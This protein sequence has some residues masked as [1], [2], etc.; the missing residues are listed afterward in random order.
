VC[1]EFAARVVSR[2]GDVAELDYEGERRS[3]SALLVPDVAVG[4]WV[5]V[6]MGTIFERLDPIEAELTNQML[7]NAQGAPT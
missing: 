6:A 2:E 3:A 7:R 4:D 1:I 5:Y